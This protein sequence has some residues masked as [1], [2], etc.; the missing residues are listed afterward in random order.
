[1]SDGRGALDRDFLPVGSDAH[2]LPCQQ[3]PSEQQVGNDFHGQ[4][5]S[6]FT[7]QDFFLARF[8]LLLYRSG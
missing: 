8:F 3:N 4:G 6:R 5:Y 1:M 2:V 7:I